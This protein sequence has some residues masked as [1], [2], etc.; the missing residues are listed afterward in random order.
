MSKKTHLLI[1]IAALALAGA[2]SAGAGQQS[3]TL[4]ISSVASIA[5]LAG[6]LRPA[7]DVIP[8][9]L[10]MPSVGNGEQHV[11]K[12]GL[13]SSVKKAAK[14]VGGAVKTAAKKV[15]SAAKKVGGAIKTGA[16]AVRAGLGKVK[17]TLVRGVD[18]I[19]RGICKVAGCKP[20]QSGL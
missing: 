4:A 1:A 13:W 11:A 12:T 8:S 6:D 2:S 20:K 14:K 5:A 18:A 10:G 16:G 15:A 9:D 7:S 17:V 3:Q 19:N